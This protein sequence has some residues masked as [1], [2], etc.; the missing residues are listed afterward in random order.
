MT[1]FFIPADKHIASQSITLSGLR[2]YFEIF[3]SKPLM[4]LIINLLFIFIPYWIFVGMS[5]LLYM[6]D[7]GVSLAHFGYY[8]GV[9][10]IVFACGSLFF[11]LMM[12]RIDVNQKRMLQ[13]NNIILITSMLALGLA[14][15]PGLA[16]PL[17]ITLAILV[18]VIG[19]II[20][21]IILYPVCLNFLPHAKGRVSAILQGSRL[22]LTAIAL[23]IAGYFYQGTFVNIGMIIIS[24]IFVAVI[25]SYLVIQS[26]DKNIKS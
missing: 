15:L 18:F 8:Q 10:A 5:P 19:Q 11:G 6:K 2:G 7:L 17:W 22:I 16:N 13:I 4:L 25:T 3:Q 21:S 26:M 1:I 14:S 20:P 9:L 23:Q 24:C 12:K